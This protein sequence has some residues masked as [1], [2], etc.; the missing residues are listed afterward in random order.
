ME[1]QL[2]LRQFL[3]SAPAPINFVSNRPLKKLANEFH[4]EPDDWLKT[5]RQIGSYPHN[6]FIVS[7]YYGNPKVFWGNHR[8]WAWPGWQH[9]SQPK[10]AWWY[11]ISPG[12]VP[13]ADTEQ[14]LFT[15]KLVYQ[16]KT[17]LDQIQ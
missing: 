7:I 6:E 12:T 2:S 10:S 4:Y 13:S 16:L 11:E 5:S 17:A 15:F 1:N 14:L 9:R 3:V 8:V